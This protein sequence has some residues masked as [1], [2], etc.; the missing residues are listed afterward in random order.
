MNTSLW[1]NMRIRKGPV[2]TIQVNLGNRCNQQC[3][4]CHVSAS[5]DGKLCMH[6]AAAEKIIARLL[7]HPG[8]EVELT[9][10]APEM[11]ASLPLFI[12]KLS[13]KGRQVTV[14]TNLT[15]LAG[16][17]YDHYYKLYCNHRVRLIASLPCYLKDNVDR[18]RG[19]GVY[20]KSL[21]VLRKL[22]ALGYGTNGLVLDLVYNPGDAALPPDQG[23]LRK[24]YAE[25][26]FEEHGIRFNRLLVLTNAPVG[27]FKEKL[28]RK[29][30]LSRYMELLCSSSNAA[31]LGSIMCRKI[32]SVDCRG[33]VY[34]CDFN[35]ALGMKIKGFK[36]RRFWEIDP[37]ALTSEITFGRHC[38]ACIAGSGSSC[39][40]RLIPE[41]PAA[42]CGSSHEH[43]VSYR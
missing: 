12:E 33:H 37:E 35:L 28:I 2:E 14:R 41:K 8:L 22:N 38:Y 9:G 1:E 18:Q 25:R 30:Q 6:K 26:L 43:S 13:A 20:E 24:A 19:D 3:S 7:E 17:D 32:I 36:S 16:L 34:D 23:Q 29:G 4:H 31:T 27:R 40:G 21:M 11:H 10:G 42:A 39:H 5:P 15:V